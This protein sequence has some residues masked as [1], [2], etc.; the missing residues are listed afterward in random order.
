LGASLQVATTGSNKADVLYQDKGRNVMAPS[1][2]PRGDTIL[3]GIGVYNLFFNGFNGT[4]FKSEDRIE[5]GAQIAIV[6]A[7]GTRYREVTSGPNNN[8]F[9]SM[10]PDGK[11]IVFRSFGPDGEGLRIM[12]LETKAVSR[13]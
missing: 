5:G 3:F 12:S 7:D 6:N 11:R 1:W 10:A 8:G 4:V 13:R 9:P 2:S